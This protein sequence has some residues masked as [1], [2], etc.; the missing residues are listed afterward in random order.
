MRVGI[1]QEA[2]CPSGT[3]WEQ[4][5]LEVIDEAI[6]ADKLGYDF[7]GFSEQHFSFYN[8]TISAPEVFLGAVAGLT[9][10]IRLRWMSAVLLGFNHPIRVLEQLATLDL[11]S[12]GRAEL[13]GARSNNRPTL[14][15]F[16]IDPTTTRAQRD[17]FLSVIGKAFTQKQFS[18][19]GPTWHIGETTIT[20]KSIQQPHPP[21]YLSATGKDSHANAGK[22]GLG[23][24]T[25]FSIL[26]WEY[27]EDCLASYRYEVARADPIAAH[28]NESA[29]VASLVVNCADTKEE[30]YEAATEMAFRFI[31]S[32]LD[33]YGDISKRST[34]YAYLG[35]IESIRDRARDLDYL[36]DCS[37]Y[38]TI[39]TP[40]FFLERFGR[41]SEL[42]YDE[43]ILRIDGMG[44]EANMAAIKS[45]GQHVLP[46]L[47]R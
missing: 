44:H 36:I 34:D 27:V 17:E 15:A 6:L 19:D 24:M 29:G 8:A 25:G 22:M 26:G 42:G 43:V 47:N 46:E 38:Y 40:D 9:E 30:A 33:M 31:D 28:V 18:H 5:Y 12:G 16:G 7:Y 35:Q 14:D 39:G 4:R 45:I 37:P 13:G 23:V 10:Q 2:I 32:M 11:I 41:L 1:L 20:P 3:T 21:L